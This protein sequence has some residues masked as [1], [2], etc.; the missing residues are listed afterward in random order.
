[1]LKNFPYPRFP[2]RRRIFKL[3][4]YFLFKIITRDLRVIGRENIPTTGPII[5]V[6]NHFSWADPAVM[7][8]LLPWPLEFL[9]GTV[10]PNAPNKFMAALPNLW[11]VYKV[12]R[13]TGSRYAFNAASA[14]MTQNGILVIFPEGGSWAEVLRPARPGVP[15]IA[16]TSG[17][18]ILPVGLDG[19]PEV[20]RTFG[21]IFY[22]RKT[23]TVRIGK[24]IGPFTVEGRGKERRQQLDAIGN[25]IMEAIAELLPPEKR[26]VFS[27][28]PK[29]I[30]EAQKVADYP[31]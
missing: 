23:I 5:I 7:I 10:T 1:M 14:I 20:F 19:V 13:G 24:P 29:L 25:T 8:R 6:G 31:W 2:V 4:G 28:D 17:A 12:Q 3:I 15:M 9:A 27:D 11:G 22:K 16:A 18:Q 21:R 30:E 26:G